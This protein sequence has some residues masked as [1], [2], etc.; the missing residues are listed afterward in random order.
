MNKYLC[1]I[2]ATIY[3]P[4][5]GDEE[6][7]VLPGTPFEELPDDW[8]CEVCGSPKSSFEVLSPEKY[9]QLISKRK[10]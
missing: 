9:E 5:L 4:D 1:R 7:G 3:D 2:C 8:T 10:K 6:Y